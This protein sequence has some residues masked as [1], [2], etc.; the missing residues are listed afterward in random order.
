MIKIAICDDDSNEIMRTRNNCLAYMA[1]YPEQDIRVSTFKQGS[2]LLEYLDSHND[3]DIMML[4]IYMPLLTGIELA[5]I[6]R[7]QNS[8]SEIIFLTSSTDHAIEAFTLNATHYLVKPYTIEQFDS[9]LLKAL[10]QLEK[11]KVAYITLKSAK[12]LHKVKFSEFI[13]AETE[14]H[15]QH[16]HLEDGVIL[17]IRITSI[18]LYELLNH[19]RRFYKCGSTYI[20]NLTKIKEITIKTILL[21]NQEIL[22][23][24]RRQYKTLID[25]YTRYSLERDS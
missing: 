12:G 13:Y 4:D 25:S 7:K 22:N 14:K 8:E 23:M 9:A 18:G 17:K 10:K 24:Q 20:L 19:D 15:F 21:D 3:F 1:K 11:K 2:V 6:I 5:K 16:I